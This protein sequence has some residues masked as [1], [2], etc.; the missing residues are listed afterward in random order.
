MQK[1]QHTPAGG[2]LTVTAAWASPLHLVQTM[3]EGLGSCPSSV[4]VGTAAAPPATAAVERAAAAGIAAVGIARV[5]TA[6]VGTAAIGTA[7][8]SASVTRLL[9]F[10][11]FYVPCAGVT[12]K[13]K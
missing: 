12:K 9:S 10:Q 11:L 6:A 2:N 4:A 7:A 13:Y 8:T 1:E 5:C 3:Y